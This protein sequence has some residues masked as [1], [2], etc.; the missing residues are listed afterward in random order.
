MKTERQNRRVVRKRKRET[1]TV[2]QPSKLAQAIELGAK[3]RQ[4]QISAMVIG[5]MGDIPC[6]DAEVEDLLWR[7]TEKGACARMLRHTLRMLRN[8]R[9]AVR[10]FDPSL[11][12]E[13]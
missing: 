4:A 3:Y 11:K 1:V 10:D 6:D 5:M 7:L 8:V 13:N 2:A 9:S 12:G